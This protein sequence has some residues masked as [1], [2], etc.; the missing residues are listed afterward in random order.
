MTPKNI[1][2]VLLEYDDEFF[3]ESSDKKLLEKDIKCAID[4]SERPR[5]S[6]ENE[7]DLVESLLMVLEEYNPSFLEYSERPWVSREEFKK[8]LLN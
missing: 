4:D 7:S 3:L 1:I 8:T 5:V 2:K 6:R